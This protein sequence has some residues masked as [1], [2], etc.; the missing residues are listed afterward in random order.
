MQVKNGS[1]HEYSAVGKLKS[2]EILKDDKQYYLSI[3]Q[4]FVNFAYSV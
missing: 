4:P 2:E 1:L 3:R